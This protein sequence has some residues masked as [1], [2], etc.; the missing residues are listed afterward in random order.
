M[1]VLLDRTPIA[2]QVCG[3]LAHRKSSRA[4]DRRV[5][6]NGAFDMNT[7]VNDDRLSKIAHM[8]PMPDNRD[9]AADS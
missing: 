7:E 4:W 6:A 8:S 5:S 2:P 1:E 3:R 9:S